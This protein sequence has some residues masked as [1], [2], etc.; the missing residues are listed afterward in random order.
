[1]SAPYFSFLTQGLIIGLA[2]S[3]PVGPTSIFCM[4]K[5]L[6]KGIVS[7]L[8]SSTG[9]ATA[10]AIQASVGAFS[11]NL[12][13]SSLAD[14]KGLFNII[15]GI[16]LCYLGIKIFLS[17][18]SINNTRRAACEGALSNR[19]IL[20]RD[21]SAALL[22]TSINPL[23]ILP[24]LAFFTQM[25]SAFNQSNP[26]WAGIFVLGVFISSIFWFGLISVVA[27]L[28]SR[29]ILLRRLHWINRIA[30]TMIA[31]FGCG[32]IYSAWS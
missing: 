24:F 28:F 15:S 32:S 20:L 23:T 4:Q 8:V 3:A 1:M 25:Y 19:N 9:A 10:N 6:T 27:N 17:H 12:V 22:L 18:F 29:R 11:L 7:G 21:Y 31:A 26:V 2:V 16:F 5:A 13:A 14:H 30:G